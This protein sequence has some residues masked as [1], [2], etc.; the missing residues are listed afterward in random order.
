MSGPSG[1]L[2][3]GPGPGPGLAMR[4]LR[5]RGQ[6]HQCQCPTVV[7]PLLA[8]VVGAAI[9]LQQQ[10]AAALRN[11]AASRPPMGWNSWG[12]FRGGV[13]AQVLRDQADAMVALG[14]RDAGYRTVNTDDGWLEVTRSAEGRLVPASNFPGGEAGMRKLSGYLHARN[15]SLGIYNSNSLTTCMRRAGGLYN[16]R[17]DAA[18]YAEWGVDYLKYDQCGQQNLQ[19]FVTFQV[20]RDALNATNRTM[21]YS[22]EPWGGGDNTRS[23]AP[24]EWPPLIGNLF[25]T[26]A[27]IRPWLA[28]TTDDALLSNDWLSVATQGGWTDPGYLEVGNGLGLDASR[29]QFAQWCII[30]T[31]LLVAMDLTKAN[32]SDPYIALLTNPELI[33]INQ[34]P[35]AHIGRLVASAAAAMA[36]TV[37]TVAGTVRLPPSATRSPAAVPAQGADA[38]ATAGAVQITDCQLNPVPVVTA[39]QRW[40]VSDDTLSQGGRCLTLTGAGTVALQ[41]C[42]GSTAQQWHSS[43][44]NASVETLSE[45]QRTVAPITKSGDSYSVVINGTRV[46]LCLAVANGRDLITEG[47]AYDPPW[48]NASGCATRIS[49][50]PRWRQLWYFATTAQL[51]S[52]Y[53]GPD[54]GH[55][56]AKLA[57]TAPPP[58]P[59]PAPVPRNL[60]KCLAT[61]NGTPPPP[62]PR[63]PFVQPQQL[64]VWAAKLSG[65]RVAVLFLNIYK[66]KQKGAI[67]A[68]Q[69][70]TAL[71]RDLFLDDDSTVVSVRDVVHRRDIGHATGSVTAVVDVDDAVV[72]VLTPV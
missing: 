61:A 32:A 43:K 29:V 15:I 71:W 3:I 54:G 37:S 13:S 51:M 60:P 45:L 47:C 36:N 14:L 53:T 9:L 16:E 42:D 41:A 11:G 5:R 55:A 21:V 57:G 23:V 31:A 52:T 35:L 39:A 34:D 65:G 70:I 26:A 6:H 24:V 72:L 10:P 1:W 58:G 8:I 44:N 25:R 69:S 40:Q 7:V 49:D 50:S 20:M 66:S 22:Y 19:P 56:A 12:H 48:C 62:P 18:T 64:Q 2:A 46:P 33:A 38:S 63:E 68:T 30:K 17:L 4:S 28:S 59:P 67:N 27:D